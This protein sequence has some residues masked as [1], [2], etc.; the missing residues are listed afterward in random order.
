MIALLAAAFLAWLGI[1]KRAS[2]Y[3]SLATEGEGRKDSTASTTP[4]G[5][6]GE[7]MGEGL[8]TRT[9]EQSDSDKKS[10]SSSSGMGQYSEMWEK[11][12]GAFGGSKSAEGQSTPSTGESGGSV[13]TD[14][15][16]IMR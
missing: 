12:K 1:T 9:G 10:E 7:N 8:D 4:T 16:G 3:W 15:W 2:I 6:G 5:D 13:S 14:G 11:L